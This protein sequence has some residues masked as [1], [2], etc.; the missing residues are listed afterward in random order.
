[1]SN[2]SGGMSLSRNEIKILLLLYQNGSMHLNAINKALFNHRYKALYWLRKLENKGL[3]RKYNVYKKW[4]P[5]SDP[6]K[7]TMYELTSTGRE[8]VKL[9]L[10]ELMNGDK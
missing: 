1:M 5:K 6:V 9:A 7:F 4:T 10:N 8:L 3:I 2:L